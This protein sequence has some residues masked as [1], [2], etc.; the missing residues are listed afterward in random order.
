[1]NTCPSCGAY[2]SPDRPHGCPDGYTSPYEDPRALAAWE[3][4]QAARQDIQQFLDGLPDDWKLLDVDE[5]TGTGE[6]TPSFTFSAARLIP[7]AFGETGEVCRGRL[8]WGGG[9]DFDV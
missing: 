1:M 8:G 7:G 2:V 5:V 3:N 6:M 4:A 9:I